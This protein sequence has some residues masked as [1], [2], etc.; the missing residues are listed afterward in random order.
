[1]QSHTKFHLQS[2]L[3]A[4]IVLIFALFSSG[5][6]QSI[7]Y[8]PIRNDV[9]LTATAVNTV[10]APMPEPAPAAPVTPQQG[11]DIVTQEPVNTAAE[12][13]NE[14]GPS[15]SATAQASAFLVQELG[16]DT[17]LTSQQEDYR[18]PIASV[19]K[20]MT[21]VVA[22]ERIGPDVPITISQAA[23]ESE[24]EAGGFSAGE[25]FTVNDLIKAMMTVSSND[26]AAAIADFMGTPRFYDLMQE[27]AAQLGM[28]N[29]SF[30]DATGLSYLNQSTAR[31]IALLVH[32]VY[33]QYPDVLGISTHKTNVIT[34][35][36]GATRTLKNINVFA[37]TLGFVG[38]KTGYT[39]ESGGNLVSLFDHQ[40]K[41]YLVIVFGATDRFGETSKLLLWVKD[42]IK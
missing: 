11:G 42:H 8:A 23:V 3:F 26:A 15:I 16:S 1:M 38:G 7:A 37:G 25:I 9:P 36:S 22:L 33:K 27:R 31:D 35:S 6:S 4:G 32:Y 28:T 41:T 12:L 18:W 21:A 20:L 2:I 19:T 5:N 39:D 10:A 34:E 24:G 14:S 29:T 40:G 17:I 30:I 13:G